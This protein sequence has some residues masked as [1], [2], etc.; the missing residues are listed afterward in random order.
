MVLV[1]KRDD[2][3]GGADRDGSPRARPRGSPIGRRVVLGMLGLGAVGVVT[4]K[5]VQDGLDALLRPIQTVDPTGL[6]GLLPGNYFRYYTVTS[7]F[8]SE[9]DAA[10][11]LKIDGRV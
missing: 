3:K 6:S 7:G 9:S 10:Y 4:G 2:P 11:R 8:P 1:P 5:R